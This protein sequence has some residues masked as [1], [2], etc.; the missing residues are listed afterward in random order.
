MF[1][2]CLIFNLLDA[3]WIYLVSLLERFDYNCAVQA[4]IPLFFMSVVAYV[5]GPTFYNFYSFFTSSSRRR[6]N[7]AGLVQFIISIYWWNL[8]VQRIVIKVKNRLLISTTWLIFNKQL[9]FFFC[10]PFCF[11]SNQLFLLLKP[12]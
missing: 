7:S 1:Y 6:T 11:G 12:T 4:L 10:K 5:S 8:I 3:L 9:I 2:I